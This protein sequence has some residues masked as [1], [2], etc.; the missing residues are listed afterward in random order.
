MSLTV[1]S[2]FAVFAVLLLLGTSVLTAGCTSVQQSTTTG[3][4]NPESAHSWTVTI[5]RIV[6][7]DTVKFQYENGTTDTGRLLGVDTPEVHTE[8]DPTEFEGIP[9]DAA[10]SS[11]LRDWGHKASEFADTELAGTRVTITLDENEGRAATTDDC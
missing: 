6:D 1:S 11:C 2:R 5:T 8:N 7:G 4:S 9:D 3:R 10:G